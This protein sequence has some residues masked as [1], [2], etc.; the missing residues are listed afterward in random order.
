[1][2]VK[3]LRIHYNPDNMDNYNYTLFDREGNFEQKRANPIEIL[4]LPPVKRFG[5][6]PI[7]TVDVTLEFETAIDSRK[8][9]RNW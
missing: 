5:F 2:K 8:I 9:H 7:E 6:C 4:D 3:T 1:M